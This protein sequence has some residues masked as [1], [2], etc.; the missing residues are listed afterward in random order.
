MRV[1][2]IVELVPR[3]RTLDV[4]A[5]FLKTPRVKFGKKVS[6]PSFSV[7]LPKKSSVVTCP[8]SPAVYIVPVRT[9]VDVE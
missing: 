7:S 4:V 1:E 8:D 5:L 6:G 3:P 2:R 9:H